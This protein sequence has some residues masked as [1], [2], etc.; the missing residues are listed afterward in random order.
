MTPV[1]R[2]TTFTEFTLPGITGVDVGGLIA[3][4]ATLDNNTVAEV[5]R[6]YPDELNFSTEEFR[7]LTV[8]E[9]RSRFYD[10]DVAYLR[11]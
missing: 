1:I 3:V 11:S 9:A 5:F 10:R 7:G 6:F 4:V 8:E 2:S